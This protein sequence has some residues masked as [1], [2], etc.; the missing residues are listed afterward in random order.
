MNK[1]CEVF[2]DWCRKVFDEQSWYSITEDVLESIRNNWDQWEDALI[3]WGY[4]NG[5]ENEQ[6]MRERLEM[7]PPSVVIHLSDV[8]QREVMR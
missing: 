5:D 6:E 8:I 2:L 1:R 3:A 7:L 4:I